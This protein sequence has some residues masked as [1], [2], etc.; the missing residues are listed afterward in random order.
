MCS[1]SEDFSSDEDLNYDSTSTDDEQIAET[2]VQKA[3]LKNQ[4]C[5]N[6]T[7]LLE[8]LKNELAK[9]RVIINTLRKNLSR[10]TTKILSLENEVADLKKKEGKLGKQLM[11]R[12]AIIKEKYENQEPFAVFLMDQVD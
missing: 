6:F 8:K 12:I 2:T 11:E 5:K 4:Q 10:K 9:K 3:H 7:S 1:S